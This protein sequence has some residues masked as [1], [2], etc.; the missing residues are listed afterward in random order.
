MPG[1]VVWFACVGAVEFAVVV[2]RVAVVAVEVDV[3]VVP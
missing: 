3:A 2:G 1:F